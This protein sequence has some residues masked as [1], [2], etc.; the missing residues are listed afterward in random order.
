MRGLHPAATPPTHPIELY[1]W[2]PPY[3]HP[4]RHGVAWAQVGLAYRREVEAYRRRQTH[5]FG[6]LPD[7]FRHARPLDEV[8]DDTDDLRLIEAGVRYGFCA[9]HEY[10]EL[11]SAWDPVVEARLEHEWS[12]AATGVSFAQL[13]EY[14]RLG[15]GLHA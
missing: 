7:T 9:R 11:Y 5:A 4:L 12:E 3:W 1:R 8:L 10:G 15:W 6:D 13:R 2:N 14:V